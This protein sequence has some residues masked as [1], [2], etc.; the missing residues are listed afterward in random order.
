[1]SVNVDIDLVDAISAAT[2]D[3]GSLT[4]AVRQYLALQG[5]PCAAM[6]YYDSITELSTATEVVMFDDEVL[7]LAKELLASYANT[8]NEIDNPLITAGLPHLLEGKV[9]RC[10]EV[11][12]F[13]EFS[14]TDY[15]Q[16]IFQPLGLRW[17]MG[18][19]AA[20]SAQEHLIFTNSRPAGT[21]A[22]SRE[23]SQ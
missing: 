17:S 10:D 19:L 6:F 9:L 22:S 14:R 1:M 21:N 20:G 13:P 23:G 7:N 4:E 5:D 11:I 16:R 15:Y 2:G 18:F 8:S 12:P 3:E